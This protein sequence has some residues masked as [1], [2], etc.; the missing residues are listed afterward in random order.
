MLDYLLNK[1]KKGNVFRNFRGGV[2]KMG[3]DYDEKVKRGNMTNRIAGEV[4]EEEG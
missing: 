1:Q 3:I 2:T 4:L